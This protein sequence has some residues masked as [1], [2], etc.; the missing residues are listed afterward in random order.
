VLFI[1]LQVCW[2]QHGDPVRGEVHGGARGRH[3]LQGMRSARGSL[4]ADCQADCKP[5]QTR[6]CLLSPPLSPPPPSLSPL[7]PA[8]S[9]PPPPPPPHCPYLTQSLAK[10]VMALTTSPSFCMAHGGWPVHH[11]PRCPVLRERERGGERSSP[12]L[13]FLSGLMKEG[14]RSS[15]LAWYCTVHSVTT[16]ESGH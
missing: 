16:C 9:V 8:L 4:I 1:A 13:C 7:P 10:R 12:H 14:E 2:G 5:C 3:S 6:F 11:K 15:P